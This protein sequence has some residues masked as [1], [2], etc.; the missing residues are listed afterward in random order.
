MESAS[1]V[2]VNRLYTVGTKHIY[3]SRGSTALVGL[4]LL[5][6]VAALGRSPPDK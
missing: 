6:S 3:F 5:Y 2:P 1:V 4:G